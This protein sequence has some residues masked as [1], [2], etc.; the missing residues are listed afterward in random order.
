MVTKYVVHLFDLL[1]FV[2]DGA[3]V[4]FC[5]CNVCALSSEIVLCMS[6]T[7]KYQQFYGLLFHRFPC[8][9]KEENKIKIYRKHSF[10]L[11]SYS[12]LIARLCCCYF[13]FMHQMKRVK[14]TTNPLL[15]STQSS[16]LTF[17]VH[18][19]VAVVVVVAHVYRFT[20]ISIHIRFS[21]DNLCVSI[22]NAQQFLVSIFNRVRSSSS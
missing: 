4:A 13:F 6:F 7:F 2:V 11:D 19:F 16:I 12:P 14:N 15:L 8:A 1:L 17:Y 5:S 10:S 21:L 18:N 3:A 9:R 20:I 22:Q